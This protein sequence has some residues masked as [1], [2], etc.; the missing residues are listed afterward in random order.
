MNY[1]F[2]YVIANRVTAASRVTHHVANGKIFHKSLIYSRCRNRVFIFVHAKYEWNNKERVV[3]D[4]AVNRCDRDRKIKQMKHM[5]TYSCISTGLCDNN[6]ISEQ[7]KDFFFTAMHLITIWHA[8][9]IAL[10][11]LSWPSLCMWIHNEKPQKSFQIFSNSFLHSWSN[12]NLIYFSFAAHAESFLVCGDKNKYNFKFKFRTKP[13]ENNKNE[14]H[15]WKSF[16]NFFWF[17]R[18]IFQIYAT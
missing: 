6:L 10:L 12:G 1:C 4:F 9:I 2:I 16:L 7:Q 15:I 11:R 18:L 8:V 13:T 3:S 5:M 17:I 14:I